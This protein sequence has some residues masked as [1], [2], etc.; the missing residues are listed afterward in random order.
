LKL[1][2]ADAAVALELPLQLASASEN[3]NEVGEPSAGKL[4]KETPKAIKPGKSVA[5]IS[6]HQT[7]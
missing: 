5:A 2:P 1:T 4:G 6:H 7:R 3:V